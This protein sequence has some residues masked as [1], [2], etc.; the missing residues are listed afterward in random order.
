MSC[1][2]RRFNNPRYNSIYRRPTAFVYTSRLKGA[3]FTA[4]L[5]H[6]VHCSPVL[7]STECLAVTRCCGRALM[8]VCTLPLPVPRSHHPAPHLLLALNSTYPP[9]RKPRSKPAP[10]VPSLRSLQR[11]SRASKD[12]RMRKQGCVT[13]RPAVTQAIVIQ[14]HPTAPAEDAGGAGLGN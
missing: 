10:P 12:G 8:Q 5:R 4:L 9:S 2:P 11:V 6:A 13:N 1:S 3:H 7:L 14:P